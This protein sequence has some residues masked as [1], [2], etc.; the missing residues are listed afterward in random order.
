MK[1]LIFLFI[2]ILA[3]TNNSNAQSDLF[4]LKSQNLNKKVA[5]TIEHYYTYHERSG[6]FVKVGI[7]INNY[8]EDGNLTQKL[9]QYN[10]TYTGLSSTTETMYNYDSKGRM[11]TTQDISAKK[12]NY[13]NYNKFTY[14]K[15]GNV[16]KKESIYQNGNKYVYNYYYDKKDRVVRVEDFDSKGKLSA[17]ENYRY[18]GNR[19]TKVRKSYDTKT[20]NVIGTYTT[21]YKKNISNRYTSKSKYSNTDVAYNYDKNDNLKSTV[22]KNSPASNTNYS[23]QYDKRDNWVKKHYKYGKT[24]NNFYFREI[25]FTNGNTTGNVDFDRNYINRNGNF[26]NVKI[27][28]I[29]KYKKIA[30]NNNTVTKSDPKMPV[31]KNKN[32]IFN[33]VNLN[34][35]A[36]SLSGEVTISVVNNDRMSKDSSVKISYSFGGKTYSDTYKVIT[37]SS[38][39]DYNFWSLKSTT[40]SSTITFTINHKK[41]FIESRDLYLAG[42]LNIKFNGK[43]TGFYLE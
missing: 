27:V 38:L 29:V 16:T 12:S 41:K 39:K 34:K 37:F 11:T 25:I 3:I 15:N 43:D 19:K 30:K 2:G 28:P 20:G 7:T 10:S 36:K 4:N 40:K 9:Y 21:Y 17:R 23:Y 22:Y 31:F 8:N 26:A 5:K 6:G 18:N 13:S 24:T 33:Y 14:D 35:K 32:F 1:K 42:M